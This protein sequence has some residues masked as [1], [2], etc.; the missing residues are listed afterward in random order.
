MVGQ[1]G[2]DGVL[3]AEHVELVLKTDIEAAAIHLQ[4]MAEYLALEH[5]ANRRRVPSNLVLVR[6]SCKKQFALLN[7]SLSPSLSLKSGP[8][9]QTILVDI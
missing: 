7:L 5:R 6:M 4:V 1:A 2:E 3:A 9:Y 8:F